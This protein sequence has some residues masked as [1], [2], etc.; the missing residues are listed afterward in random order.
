MAATAQRDRLPL[1]CLG[2]EGDARQ[3]TQGA[4]LD[5]GRGEER[6]ETQFPA[7]ESGFSRDAEHIPHGSAE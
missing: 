3:D 5:L 6:A 2:F 4:P 1:M 7:S